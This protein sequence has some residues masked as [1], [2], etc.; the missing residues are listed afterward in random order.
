MNQAIHAWQLSCELPSTYTLFT[1]PLTLIFLLSLPR[2]LTCP[3]ALP[4]FI[5][6]I[7]Q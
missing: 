5:Q 3:V 6:G 2:P 4:L 7:A 1:L